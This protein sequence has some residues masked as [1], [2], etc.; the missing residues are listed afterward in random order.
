DSEPG[1]IVV[2]NPALSPEMTLTTELG[3][4][5]T[6]GRFRAEASVYYTRLRD[7]IVRRPFVFNDADSILYD[8]GLSRVSALVNAGRGY[9]WGWQVSTEWDISLNLHWQ[10]SLT[11]TDGRDQT[12]DIPLRHIPPLFVQ[13]TLSWEKKRWETRF[14]VQ[15]HAQKPFS[16]LSPSEQNKIHLYT[17]DGTPAWWTLNVQ[18]GYSFSEALVLRIGLENILDRHYRPFS[19]GI[20]AAGRNLMVSF[21]GRF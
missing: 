20:S 7:A 17:D 4:R 19:S 2:P 1:N 15:A 10:A 9:V 18:V 16:E 14:W 8:G 5:K 6:K 11:Y 13:T 12:E 21:S 3:W